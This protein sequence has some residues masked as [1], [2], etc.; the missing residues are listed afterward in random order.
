MKG[1]H[2]A[3]RWPGYSDIIHYEIIGAERIDYQY[4]AAATDG[5]RGDPHGVVKITSIEL[6]G[7]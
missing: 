2:S 4:N 5:A 7:H 6:G 1:K 3:P